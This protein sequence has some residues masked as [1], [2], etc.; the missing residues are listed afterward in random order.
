MAFIHPQVIV[1]A[2][3]ANWP[4][5]SYSTVY[6]IVRGLDPGLVTLAH[7]GPAR[8]RDR[9]KLDYRREAER[10]NNVWQADHTLLDVLVLDH[11]GRPAPVVDRDLR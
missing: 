9:Y 6:A 4:A 5:P 10:P 8:Y 3:R 2:A 7:D 1:A 11:A